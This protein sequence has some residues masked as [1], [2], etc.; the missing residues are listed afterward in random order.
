MKRPASRW[1]FSTLLFVTTAFSA[2]LGAS[3]S[4]EADSHFSARSV[5]DYLMVIGVS[6]N[7]SQP[8]DF[9]IDTG[10]NT[11]LIDPDLATELKLNPVDRMSLTTLCDA[12]TVIRYYADNVRIGTASVGHVE[13]LGAPLT[14]LRSLDHRIRGVLGMNFLLQFSFLLDYRHH[15]FQIF[16]FPD[17]APTPQGQRVKIQIHDSRILVPVV[18]QSAARGT[19]NLVLDSGVVGLVLFQSR[20]RL[21]E[22]TCM[23][24]ICV[25]QVATNGG[26]HAAATGLVPEMLVAE[27]RIFDQPVAILRN[28]VLN[29]S[30][31]QDGLLPA[32]MF[33][34]VFFDRSN[35][36]LIVKGK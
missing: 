21:P 28:E 26:S 30:D 10:T 29:P 34:S 33:R 2:A 9:L 36:T 32:S 35:G 24:A 17:L 22:R 25:M 18:S 16:P 19:W 27:Q 6:I 4:A 20:T 13:L 14:E 1:C 11:T 5:N 12:R 7:G 8:F 3:T 23:E 15:N 31:P